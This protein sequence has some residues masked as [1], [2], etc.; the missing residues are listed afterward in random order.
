LPPT[1]FGDV[2]EPP[3][4]LLVLIGHCLAGLSNSINGMRR[5]SPTRCRYYDGTEQVAPP[6]P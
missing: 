2:T 3:T 4:E 6:G 5:S 1:G